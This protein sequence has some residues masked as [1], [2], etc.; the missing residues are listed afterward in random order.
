MAWPYQ[1]L[2]KNIKFLPCIFT[3]LFALV[4]L[5]T[6][7][8][9]THAAASIS[10]PNL[11]TS[12]NWSG[13]EAQGKIGSFNRAQIAFNVPSLKSNGD[14]SVWAG[15]GG[16]PTLLGGDPNS[17]VLVQA[18]VDSCLGSSCFGPC[19]NPN[20]Q[21]NYAWWEIADALVVQPIR[22]NKPISAGNLI[23]VYLESNFNNKGSDILRVTDLT[24]GESHTILVA[25]QVATKD[26]QRI[27]I[28]TP[29]GRSSSLNGIKIITDGASAECI[30]ERPLVGSLSGGS[31]TTLPVV[32]PVNILRCDVGN[33]RLLEAIS[34]AQPLNQI[35]MVDRGTSGRRSLGNSVRGANATA[36]IPRLRPGPIGGRYGDAFTL[37]EPTSQQPLNSTARFVK[38]PG[39][40]S[41]LPPGS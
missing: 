27:S 19:P 39:R 34:S 23:A 26:G 15:L 37:A 32:P 36:D 4:G 16:D 20:I 35:T 17:A 22:F 31:F 33:S 14:M 12:D 28:I 5:S 3:L 2:A 30:G 1:Q 11:V 18:G 8:P 13:D 40:S 24:I 6:A 7:T 10:S 29:N 21:C 38:F 25:N 9:S 41:H